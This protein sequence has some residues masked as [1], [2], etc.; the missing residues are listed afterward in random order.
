MVEDHTQPVT[1]P[2]GEVSGYRF[3]ARQCQRCRRILR[4]E[5]LIKFVLQFLTVVEGDGDLKGLVF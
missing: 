4:I 3:A 5:K 2:Q 1:L